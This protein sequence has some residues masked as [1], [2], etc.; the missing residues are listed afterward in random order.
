MENY[1]HSEQIL[2]VED[3]RLQRT[4]IGASLHQLGYSYTMAENG[5]DALGLLQDGGV[6]L[7]L[8]DLIL[9][10]M[11]GYEVLEVMRTDPQLSSIPVIVISMVEDLES[12]IRCIKAGASD[13]LIKPVNLTLLSARIDSCLAQRRLHES[14][15]AYYREIE[16]INDKLNLMNNITRHDLANCVQIISGYTDF[17]RPLIQ[18][19]NQIKFVQGISKA[20]EDIRNI[21]DFTKIYQDIG[22]DEPSWQNLHTIL[23]HII[24]KPR[25]H[26]LKLRWNLPELELLADIMIERVFM[27]L[28]DN[29][30][31]HGGQ[32]TTITISGHETPEGLTL[33][34]ADD[35]DGISAADKE[36]IFLRGYGKN[37]GLGLF[38]IRE[39][40]QIS[41][42]SIR[43]NGNPGEGARFEMKIP[44]QRYRII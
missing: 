40:L 6:D 12:I 23:Q 37:T 38:L 30:L 1:S 20:V 13:Y 4:I 3:E 36:R 42:M 9:P 41:D 26:E 44:I 19:K 7:V 29:S 27:N 22:K 2:L 24:Q 18:E 14:E 16:A 15:S 25:Y 5:K 32:V 21:L 39:I 28:V 8:L 10:E 17:L 35:G 43:E 31:R 11:N 34:Y 33:Y